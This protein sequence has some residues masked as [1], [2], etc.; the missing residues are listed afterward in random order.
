MK[1]VLTFLFWCVVL[2]VCFLIGAGLQI[3]L[4]PGKP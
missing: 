4:A 2:F 1:R 3:W